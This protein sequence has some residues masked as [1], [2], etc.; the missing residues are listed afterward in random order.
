ME[1]IT[2]ESWSLPLWHRLFRRWFFSPLRGEAAAPKTAQRASGESWQTRDLPHDPPHDPWTGN[3]GDISQGKPLASGEHPSTLHGAAWH[4]FGWLRDMRDYGGSQARINARH[5]ILGWITENRHWSDHVWHPQMVSRRLKMMIL[6]WDWFAAPASS[7]DQAD[8]LRTMRAHYI[9]LGK[10]WRR[11]A[12]S[13]NRLDSLSSLIL[14]AAF[15]DT[16]DE[17]QDLCTALIDE[18]RSQIFNDGCHASRQP[19]RHF[20]MLRCLIEARLGL[21]AM[22]ARL[23]KDAAAAT[24]LASLDDIIMRM[25]ALARM[26]RHS[27]GDLL[28]ILGSYESQSNI[29]GE[30]LDRAVSKGRITNHASDSGFIRLASSRSTMLMNIAP[31]A[32]DMPKFFNNGGVIDGGA[33][34]I[35][36]SHGNHKIITNT[37]QLKSYQQDNPA[38]AKPLA[39]TP[40]FS[41]LT[42]DKMNSS[43]LSD[44]G[45][46]PKPIRRI[47]MATHSERGAASSGFLAEAEHNGY[48]SVYGLLHRRR[49][50]LS[51]DGSDLRGEDSLRYT[52]APGPIPSEAVIRFHLH[53][54]ISAKLSVGGDVL[55]RIGSTTTIWHFKAQS[56]K[57]AC[58][59]E[60]DDSIFNDGKTIVKTTQIVLLAELSQIRIH[61]EKIIKWGLRRQS[62][63]RPK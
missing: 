17:L 10:D 60:L 47:A 13:D 56:D 27:N 12:V 46:S 1:P 51:T 36:F 2:L 8:F 45:A 21:A 62:I 50:F 58:R 20:S 34:A 39:S 33:L 54:R 30:I 41:T 7:D 49:I 3:A 59:I 53:P 38:L 32:P 5:F 48:E 28:N 23:P 22:V 43:D 52:G 55:L 15:L 40:A 26:W 9:Q 16:A 44:E 18:A 37:G 29:I 61:H 57:G 6:M 31:K 25:G 35:E 14:G 42:I 24:Y 11:L 63:S 4:Q 19:D